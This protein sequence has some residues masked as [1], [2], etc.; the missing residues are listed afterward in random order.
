MP[1]PRT[2]ARRYIVTFR[3]GS[4]DI[5]VAETNGQAQYKVIQKMAAAEPGVTL[6]TAKRHILHTRLHPKDRLKKGPTPGK[7]N[8]YFMA[9]PHLLS[10]KRRRVYERLLK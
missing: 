10:A 7:P 4:T 2:D 9:N 6:L 3:D 5:I 8:P 1:S